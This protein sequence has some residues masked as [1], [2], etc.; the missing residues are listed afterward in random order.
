MSD[1]QQ[2]QLVV[3]LTRSANL[4]PAASVN[5]SIDGQL[6]STE[7]GNRLPAQAAYQLT[8]GAHTIQLEAIDNTGEKRVVPG[9]VNLA[10]AAM[11]ELPMT[12]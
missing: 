9:Q 2:A 7:T 10:P 3:K 12:L 5:V 8:P 11:V 1:R 6:M 4:L